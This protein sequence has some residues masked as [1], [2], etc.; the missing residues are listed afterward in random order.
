MFWRSVVFRIVKF[1]TSAFNF[2]ILTVLLVARVQELDGDV[3]DG[4]GAVLLVEHGELGVPV[5]AEPVLRVVDGDEVR[6]Q[7]LVRLADIPSFSLFRPKHRVII[8]RVVH[9]GETCNKIC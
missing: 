2:H 8:Q 9:D 6:D 1:N 4:V 5:H 3:L 7:L